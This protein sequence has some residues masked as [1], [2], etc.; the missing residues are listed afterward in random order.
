VEALAEA[1]G[2]TAPYTIY[3]GQVLQIP[4]P[5]TPIPTSAP[6]TPTQADAIEAAKAA[7]AEIDRHGKVPE[8]EQESVKREDG[9]EVFIVS[10]A[11][12]DHDNRDRAFI[13]LVWTIRNRV[14]MYHS[15]QEGKYNFGA[16]DTFTNCARDPS[17][18]AYAANRSY[19]PDAHE[20][21]VAMR[22]LNREIPDPTGG[23]TFFLSLGEG[24][25]EPIHQVDNLTYM[26]ANVKKHLKNPDP[27][28][29]DFITLEQWAA[30]W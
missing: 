25:D 20:V 18:E 8:A 23:A 2:I 16:C 5:S 17:Y 21:E 15:S 19:T 27:W 1:N 11:W 6:P 28:G 14:D 3:P 29:F 7:G 9:Q 10:K 26:D 13:P 4:E 22:V 30:G 24:P 12:G